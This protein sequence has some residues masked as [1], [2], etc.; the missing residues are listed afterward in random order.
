[1]NQIDT[2]RSLISEVST[3]IESTSEKKQGRLLKR[4][5]KKLDAELKQLNKKPER[6]REG[7]TTSNLP[8]LKGVLE[9]YKNSTNVQDILC[10]MKHYGIV[11]DVICDS[12]RTWKKVVA[13]N[14]QSTHLIWAGKGQYGT[15]D[16][17]RTAK[18]YIQAAELFC[19][20]SP[21]K[22]I[23]IF[24]NGVTHD[25]AEY[26]EGLGVKVEGERVD[27]HEDT[28]RRLKALEDLEDSEC[29][30]EDDSQ[31]E[32]SEEE[33]EDNEECDILTREIIN[34]D[35]NEKIFLD[36]TSMVIY[37]SDVCNGGEN[38]PFKDPVM[39]EQAQQEQQKPVM[40]FMKEFF[41]N[42]KLV[43]CQTAL[44]NFKSFVQ[45]LGGEEEKRRAEEL[46]TR[47]T[48]VPDCISTRFQNL[49]VGGKVS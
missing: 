5:M 23:C 48:V 16:V 43:T 30:Y 31:S 8:H 35:K 28:K 34:M 29:E 45:L 26:L 39:A 13:R 42:R 49:K 22:V 21:P 1:M 12:G 17:S 18:K 6:A 41:D 33:E 36:V 38:F 27:V 47:I 40:S 32:T 44:D 11:V 19:E 20:L 2:A 4:L 37:V 46:M 14:A 10:D 25:L 3:L 15:K 9:T 24:M 7:K